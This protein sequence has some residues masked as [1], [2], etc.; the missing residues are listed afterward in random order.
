M[1]RL[2]TK[3]LYQVLA[4]V[5]TIVALATG[6]PA[7]ADSSVH[8]YEPT[9]SGGKARFQVSRT[10]GDA[11]A[12]TFYYRTINLTAYAGQHYTAV[13]GELNFAPDEH[14]KYIYVEE[15]TPE[16]NAYIY[17]NGITER[18]YKLE[19]TDLMGITLSEQTRTITNCGT[20]VDPSTAY[21]Q[22][23]YTIYAGQ[24]NVTDEGFD[25]NPYKARDCSD[26]FAATAP[27]GYLTTA[28]SEV[29]TTFAFDVWELEDGYQHFQVLVDNT[30][31]CDTDNNNV[32]CGTPVKSLY[33]VSMAH[34]PGTRD[35]IPQNY[36]FPLTQY[37]DFTETIEN[38]WGS[39]PGHPSRVYS[40][41]FKSGHRAS[42]GKLILPNNFTTLVVRFDA[43]GNNNDD[44][45][46][47]NVV[48][49]M[50]NVDEYAPRHIDITANAGLH[51]RRNTVYVTVAFNEIVTLAE[52]PTLTTN[53]GTLDYVT[54]DNT[55]VLTFSGK[56]LDTASTA[57][58]VTGYTGSIKDLAGNEVTGISGSNLAPLDPDLTYTLD[59]FQRDADG[60]YLIITHDDLHGLASYTKTH[61]TAGLSFLQICNIVFPY[62][63][64]WSSH[65]NTEENFSGIGY[66]FEFQGTYDG[67]G[68]NIDNLRMYRNGSSSNVGLFLRIG[69]NGV[70]RN[71]RLRSV[72]FAGYE[73]V[74]G[75]AGSTSGIIEDCIF[76]NGYIHAVQESSSCYGGI[77][78][79]LTG[80]NATIRRCVSQANISY[81]SGLT[82]CSK[83][84]GI[85]GSVGPYTTVADNIVVSA[86]IPNVR[87]R[88][89]IAGCQSNATF[90]N[91][92]YRSC[93]VAGTSDAKNVG[94]GT[95]G[96]TVSSDY[97]GA[98]GLFAI[99]L[100]N[101]TTYERTLSATLAPLSTH[102]YK[103]YNNG[104]VISNQPYIYATAPV[105]LTYDSSK[106][107]EGN[108]FRLDITLT[109]N[110]NPVTFTDNDDYTYDFTMPAAA[111][112]VTTTQAE[113]ISY[114][115]AAGKERWLFLSECKEIYPHIGTLVYRDQVKWF[116]VR[117]G[118]YEFDV[119][120]NIIAA[121]ANIIFCDGVVANFSRQ[122]QG[123]SNSEGGIAI[124]GQ[125]AGNAK[126]TIQD[127]QGGSIDALGDI[128]INGCDITVKNFELTY[129]IISTNGNI[130]IRRGNVTTFS[131]YS[132][133]FARKDVNILGGTVNASCGDRVWT[134]SAIYAQGN[135]NI[136]GGNV[137]AIGEANWPGIRA[138]FD[139]DKTITFGWTNPSDHINVDAVSCGTLNVI[140]GQT[141]TDGSGAVYSGTLTD[142]QKTAI[143]GK[144]LRPATTVT[145][146]KEGYGTAYYGDYD[147]VLPA[148]MKARI[149]TSKGTGGALNYQTIAN[150]NTVNNVVPKATAVM[151]QTA[152]TDANQTL[153]VALAEPAA[154]AI[155]DT[156]FLYGSDTAT[157]TDN[158]DCYDVSPAA[159]AKYYKL[160]YDQSGEEIAW[161]WGSD[162][163]TPFTSG[164]HKVWL[165]LPGGTNA[166][167]FLGL[168]TD[169]LPTG[170]AHT[171]FTAH[172]DVWYDL[173]G[174]KLND[175]PTAKGIYVNN[176][177]KVVIK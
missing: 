36:T 114:I 75:I 87:A 65:D 132:G 14:T 41:K 130:T 28:G 151:L 160:S 55:N 121:Q 120:V 117:P 19:V 71:I 4:A 173:S 139:Y 11:F 104:A 15:M 61:S 97:D 170:I 140:D 128:E 102:D 177:R 10:S 35:D 67:G 23:N 101:N 127:G 109:D 90:T 172:A 13:S 167:S 165:V 38:P 54:G 129:S 158:A 21:V 110:G 77:T 47:R 94:I 39:R 16:D 171:D 81:A 96:N 108:A 164:A 118:E 135:V 2:T 103:T 12:Q 112:T 51:R 34:D 30:S 174:R 76:G 148:G 105:H 91:N 7:N 133:I 79:L 44:W 161:Y 115:D 122:P 69:E 25:K 166:P 24:I 125:K 58:N 63:S 22:H 9:F 27:S 150:G 163:G 95:N 175:K 72:Y 176:G 3:N 32:N 83:F 82:N 149:V 1:K 147:L 92:Y 111:V 107:A 100:A 31:T 43:S 56:I 66:P 116:Y 98:R 6:Q 146:A 46:A 168:P 162:N 64:N 60:N 126:I 40:Q 74:G 17:Q 84:G 134:P 26:F 37:G 169:D 143:G 99:N 68:Y 29:R 8:I 153:G 159:D 141:L 152:A 5:L 52:T 80:P 78:G 93:R 142:E 145:F 33:L 50:Q 113:G 49:N 89:A 45:Y 86:T 20:S 155:T 131:N 59:D 136:L 73:N 57:L 70:V 48:T 42:D 154:D 106:I 157:A 123:I 137:T 85:V 124:Y 88:G 144:T 119:H 156:N 138:G 18:S 62:K 53:W